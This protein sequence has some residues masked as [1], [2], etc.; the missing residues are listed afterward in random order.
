MIEPS[1]RIKVTDFLATDYEQDVFKEL[2][3][4][5]QLPEFEGIGF[6]LYFWYDRKT[7]VVDLNTL[8]QF[9]TYWK[10]SGEYATKLVIYPELFDTQNDFIWYDIRPSNAT[11]YIDNPSLSYIQYYRFAYNYTDPK[12]GVL[13]GLQDFQ[14][15][16]IF[17]NRDN[18]S[19]TK[20]KQKRN[21][22]EN[23]NHR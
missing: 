21:D 5:K 23:S 17:V 8:Q 15:K 3:R 11:D 9:I 20:R 1:L 12:T 4:I 13:E 10:S 22:D 16:F 2:M 19:D 18:S 14:E 7:E 6:P